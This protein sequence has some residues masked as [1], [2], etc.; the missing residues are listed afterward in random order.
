MEFLHLRSEC[1][2]L[3]ET[4]KET[5]DNRLSSTNLLRKGHYNC[6]ARI[7]KIILQKQ[8]LRQIDFLSMAEGGRIA[9]SEVRPKKLQS[10]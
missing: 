4:Q 1:H 5:I 10:D 6:N 8:K 2:T 7:V 3:A 9:W